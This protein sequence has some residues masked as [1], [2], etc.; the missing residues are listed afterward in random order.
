MTQNTKP[1]TFHLT[2]EQQEKLV[3]SHRNRAANQK[4]LTPLQKEERLRLAKN[5]EWVIARRKARQV[6]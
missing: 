5:L 4:S 3:E 1:P 2:I 6:Q